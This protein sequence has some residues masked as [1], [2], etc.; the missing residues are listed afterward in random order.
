[1]GRMAEYSME[2][3][4]LEQENLSGLNSEAYFASHPLPAH[5]RDGYAERLYE[6]A[7]DARKAARERI[8][9]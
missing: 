3:Q 8:V 7:D 5:K 9:F 4:E 6:A 1:M 2:Q